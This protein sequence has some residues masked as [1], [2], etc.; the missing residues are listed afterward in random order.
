[1]PPL[2]ADLSLGT[3]STEKGNTFS[4]NKLIRVLAAVGVLVGGC[5]N[6]QEVPEEWVRYINSIPGP[7]NEELLTIVKTKQ[8]YRGLALSAICANPDNDLEQLMSCCRVK[9]TFEKEE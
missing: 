9:F 4:R 3:E 6:S 5:S 2:E 8:R 1:M 7:T